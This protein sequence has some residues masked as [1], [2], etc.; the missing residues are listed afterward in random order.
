MIQNS[1]FIYQNLLREAVCFS[2]Y[3]EREK[4][5]EKLAYKNKI[6][7]LCSGLSVY[8]LVHTYSLIGLLKNSVKGTIIVSVVQWPERR[9]PVRPGRMHSSS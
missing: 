8:V 9:K 7:T 2:V 6:S 5:R 1:D 3:V 4:Y